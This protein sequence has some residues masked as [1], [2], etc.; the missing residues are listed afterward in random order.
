MANK[1]GD[2][3]W[4]ELLTSDPDA[5]QAFYGPILGWTFADS[6]MPDQDY[7]I[8]SMGDIG[9]GG[10]MKVPEGAPMPP[11][12]MGY[13]DVTDVDASVA[14]IKKAGGSVYMEPQDIPNVGRLA[15]MAD[16]QGAAFYIIAGASAEA[17][18]AFAADEPRRGHCAWNELLTTDQAGAQAFYTEQFGWTKDDEMDMGEMGK[19]DLMRHG[20]MIGGIMTK[21]AEMP[22]P[23]WIYY[24]RVAGIDAAIAA[25]NA[26]GGQVLHGPQEI[27][28][29]EF[30]VNAL[31]PQGAVFALVGPRS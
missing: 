20:H 4:Y 3:V 30:V 5:A 26:T 15:L 25:I 8:I 9:V 11:C 31:D 12:W 6:G 29:G 22:V 14:A 28:G 18:Q 27:P 10:L 16:P 1:H 24:F 2:F 13:I 19:Y 17:S 21:P 7:R 23:A